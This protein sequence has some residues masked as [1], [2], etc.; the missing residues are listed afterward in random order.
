MKEEKKRKNKESKLNSLGDWKG[1]GCKKLHDPFLV[2]RKM[3]KQI[4]LNAI[5]S[6]EKKKLN[7]VKT[8]FLCKNKFLSNKQL[9]S[10]RIGWGWS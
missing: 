4:K 10:N 7:Y 3:Y 6:A 5:A 8:L 1:T 2:V 9:L